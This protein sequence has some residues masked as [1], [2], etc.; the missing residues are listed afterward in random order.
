M[1]DIEVN[2]TSV[3]YKWDKSAQTVL[4]EKTLWYKLLG[5]KKV[6]GSKETGFGVINYIA[7]A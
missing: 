1:K 5:N 3:S 7:L 6:V 2:W 4:E